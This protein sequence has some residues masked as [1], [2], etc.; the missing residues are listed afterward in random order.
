ME[1]IICPICGHDMTDKSI[2][3]A[4]EVLCPNCGN[5][6]VA[7]D[8]QEKD[9]L[10]SDKTLYELFID[11]K[12]VDMSKLKS[13]SNITSLT[14]VALKKAISNGDIILE[15]RAHDIKPILIKLKEIDCDFHTVPEFKHKY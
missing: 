3:Y 13:I 8:D 4:I 11:K 15:M 1:K 7:Y 9:A 12:T 10:Y 5:G 2:G 14:M 6:W